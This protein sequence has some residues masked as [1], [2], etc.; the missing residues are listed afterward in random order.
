MA[1][2]AILKV[3]TCKL[4]ASIFCDG[5]GQ[6]G[7]GTEDIANVSKR[8]REFFPY[9]LSLEPR[10]HSFLGI[11]VRVSFHHVSLTMNVKPLVRRLF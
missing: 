10:S 3:G 4:E 2:V 8:S 1:A 11:L 6:P 5:L 7:Y 9:F